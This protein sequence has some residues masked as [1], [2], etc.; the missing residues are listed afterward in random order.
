MK[1]PPR[2]PNCLDCK[3]FEITYDPYF[4][5]A[6]KI[7]GIQTA[8]TLPSLNVFEA[9]GLHCPRFKLNKKVKKNKK[10]RDDNNHKIS[11]LA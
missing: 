6:C 2:A 1:T 9:T 5:R 4:P 7:F 8:K 3:Y 11:F 10:N